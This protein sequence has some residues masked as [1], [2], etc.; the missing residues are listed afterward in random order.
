MVFFKKNLNV[1]GFVLLYV[2]YEK[3]FFFG[4]FLTWKVAL[5]DEVWFNQGYLL[6]KES[7]DAEAK[8]RGILNL[9]NINIKQWC[10]N[11]VSNI[12]V[13][14]LSIDANTA[15]NIVVLLLSIDA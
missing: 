14:L 3:L 6:R 12:V 13:L 8:K 11:T 15:S 4:N 2:A 9:L 1:G 7:I 5:W 10:S